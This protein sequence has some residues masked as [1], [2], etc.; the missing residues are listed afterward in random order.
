MLK[1]QGGNFHHGY[2]TTVLLYFSKNGIGVHVHDFSSHNNSISNE[3]VNTYACSRL[4]HNLAQLPVW[5]HLRQRRQQL[6]V[7]REVAQLR[8]ACLPALF[9]KHSRGESGSTVER[10]RQ[11]QPASA[12]AAQRHPACT[13]SNA[14]PQTEQLHSWTIPL[15]L[16]V[17]LSLLGASH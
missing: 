1:H 2:H 5:V 16:R 6:T 8:A 11:Q 10:G 13:N 7:E 9:P 4:Q 3:S 17:R 12:S 14:L 15:T